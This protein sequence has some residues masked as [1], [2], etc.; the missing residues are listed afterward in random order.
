MHEYK[1]NI[2]LKFL[3]YCQLFIKPC[4]SPFTKPFKIITKVKPNYE[5]FDQS[6]F[7]TK[8]QN[9]QSI[10]IFPLHYCATFVTIKIAQC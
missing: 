8:R 10:D 3:C 5:G 2:H 1:S 6:T 4:M 9:D 7:F